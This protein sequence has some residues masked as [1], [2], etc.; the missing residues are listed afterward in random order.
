ML[1]PSFDLVAELFLIM[2]NL[3][4]KTDQHIVYAD[5]DANL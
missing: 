5:A 3:Y 4:L 2:T 1:M